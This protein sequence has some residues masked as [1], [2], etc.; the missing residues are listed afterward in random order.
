MEPK[1]NKMIPFKILIKQKIIKIFT[2]PSQSLNKEIFP[3]VFIS[4]IDE[5]AKNKIGAE[6]KIISL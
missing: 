5:P 6:L 1:G 2:E 4:L 3:I